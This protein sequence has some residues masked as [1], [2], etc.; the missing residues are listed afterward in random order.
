MG[1][2][3]KKA[4]AAIHEALDEQSEE[5]ARHDSRINRLEKLVEAQARD[6]AA[7][8]RGAM[9]L[10]NKSIKAAVGAGIPTNIVAKAHNVTSGR[11]S[12]IAPR[13]PRGNN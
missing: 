7:I 1:K 5:I 11:I 6:I 12:Q 13:T 8:E 2:K 9:E 10:R 3:T 4:L